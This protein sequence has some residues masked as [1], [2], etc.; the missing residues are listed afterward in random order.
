M[1]KEIKIPS[2][3]VERYKFCDICGIEIHIGLECSKAKCHYCKKDLCEKCI[4]HEEETG[5]DYRDV[6][7]KKCW[8][9][10]N[11]FRPTI[12]DLNLKITALY[13]KWRKQCLEDK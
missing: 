10:G 8:T 13:N 5:G 6:W 12:E 11:N 9:I 1:I 7:C 2:E 3:K 4:G